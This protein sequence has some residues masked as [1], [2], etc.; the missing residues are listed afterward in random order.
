M[1][2]DILKNSLSGLS[3]QPLPP[4][5]TGLKVPDAT[6]NNKTDISNLS[7]AQQQPSTMLG[8]QKALQV[9][10]QQAYKD[11]QAQEMEITSGQF[12]PTKVSGGTFA[13]IIGNLEQQRGMDISKVYA[14]TMSTYAK[15][16]D[17]ISQR[18]MFLEDLERQK[19]E[20]KEEM[21]LRKKELA[22]LEKADKSAAKQFKKSL[23]EEQRQFDMNYRQTSSKLSMANAVDS[24]SAYD[25][26]WNQYNAGSSANTYQPIATNII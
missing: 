20:F 17:T 1:A 22:R 15:V 2:D 8:L 14:S 13:G 7:L 19:E 18:L 6:G 9:G 11:R 5:P 26:L 10:S 4:T 23:E 21:K 16:Q 12:D 24:Q 25:T 3:S